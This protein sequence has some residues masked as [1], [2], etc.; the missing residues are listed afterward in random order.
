MLKS[1]L[2]V[3]ESRGD[4][5]ASGWAVREPEHFAAEGRGAPEVLDSVHGAGGCS[6]VGSGRAAAVL[7]WWA[8]R[9]DRFSPGFL[10]LQM[11]IRNLGLWSDFLK[12][13]PGQEM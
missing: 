2:I 5:G 10:H 12:Q 9:R 6:W 3:K 7:V 8:G 13:P 11:L 1:H 4:P